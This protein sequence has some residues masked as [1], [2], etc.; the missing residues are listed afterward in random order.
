L[1]WVSEFSRRDGT[2]RLADG[3]AECMRALR[4]PL[5]AGARV[6]KV[7]ASG[8]ALSEL[9]SPIYQQF[10]AAELRAIVEVAGLADRM[11]AAHCPPRS[12][13]APWAPGLRGQ[14]CSR[15]G[16]TRTS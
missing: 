2:L 3:T 13:R 15:P 16:M 1:S 12:R 10:T 8:G 5:R 11:V 7:C 9:D 4:D 6:I 14:A